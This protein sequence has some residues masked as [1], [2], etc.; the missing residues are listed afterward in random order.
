MNTENLLKSLDFILNKGF[1]VRTIDRA[2]REF[3][4]IKPYLTVEDSELIYKWMLELD[5]D[6]PDYMPNYAY[7]HKQFAFVVKQTMQ[8]IQHEQNTKFIRNFT[9]S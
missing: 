2:W 5:P 1:C 9:Q 3:D 7:A 6:Y 4:K 8:H